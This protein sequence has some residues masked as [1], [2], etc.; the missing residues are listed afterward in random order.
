MD[1]QLY[2]HGKRDFLSWVENHM[3]SIL[4]VTSHN[5]FAKVHPNGAIVRVYSATRAFKDRSFM[6]LSDD[7]KLLS[8]QQAIEKRWKKIAAGGFFHYLRW[9]E[10]SS[11]TTK[12]S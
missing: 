4:G 9:L 11:L 2:E 8:Y 12:F 7:H 1:G 10:Y 3:F 6:V 5:D